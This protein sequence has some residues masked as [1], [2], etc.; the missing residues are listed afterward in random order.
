MG[1]RGKL[2]TSSLPVAT[3]VNKVMD[4]DD[5][6]QERKWKAEEA[7]RTIERAEE[8]R[9]DKSL[10]KDVKGLAK[11]KMNNLKKIC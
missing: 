7:L 9:K 1:A 4:R 5:N 10:M 3:A 2:P 11:Y 6:T 8:H